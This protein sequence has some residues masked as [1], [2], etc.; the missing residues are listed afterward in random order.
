MYTHS[1]TNTYQ[2]Y[3]YYYYYDVIKYLY[4]LCKYS[5]SAYSAQS[6][7]VRFFIRRYLGITSMI[8]IV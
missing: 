4:S 8:V 2:Y 3:H 1:T 7:V 6:K 5:L